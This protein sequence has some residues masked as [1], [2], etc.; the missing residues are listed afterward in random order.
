M[1]SHG[2]YRCTSDARFAL[3]IVCVDHYMCPAPADEAAGGGGVWRPVI[4][5]FGSTP[6]G[7][8]CVMI[9]CRV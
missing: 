3:R 8:R 4:R 1:A 9:F 2:A 7:Q 6:A 5:I